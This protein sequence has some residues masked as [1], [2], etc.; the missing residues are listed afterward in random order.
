MFG[1]IYRLQHR[2]WAPNNTATP[3]WLTVLQNP[4]I[5]G[6]RARGLRALLASQVTLKYITFMIHK[7]EKMV[8]L[9]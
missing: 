9:I 1:E 6:S 2:L 4:P 8:C 7:K 3:G 5:T